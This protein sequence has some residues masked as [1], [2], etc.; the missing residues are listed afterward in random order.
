VVAFLETAGGHTNVLCVAERQNFEAR[1]REFEV[2]ASG[3]T[4]LKRR[5]CEY[6]TLLSSAME[7]CDLTVFGGTFEH[8]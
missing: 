8:A 4:L 7:D 5:T 3:L 6:R 2:V 1:K